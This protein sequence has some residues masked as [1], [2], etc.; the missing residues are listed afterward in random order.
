MMQITESLAPAS[1]RRL[2]GRRKPFPPVTMLALTVILSILCDLSPAVHPAPSSSAWSLPT[3]NYLFKDTKTKSQSTQYQRDNS[4]NSNINGGSG[5]HVRHLQKS[6]AGGDDSSPSNI[7]SSSGSSAG[8]D[9]KVSSTGRLISSHDIRLTD[10]WGWVRRG[11]SDPTQTTEQRRKQNKNNIR[12]SKGKHKQRH[13]SSSSSSHPSPSF[14][15]SP[16]GSRSRKKEKMENL[17][18]PF[19]EIRGPDG[20]C[21]KAPRFSLY[22]V[23]RK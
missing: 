13:Y 2:A 3:L 5:S 22:R 18:C 16:S 14:S 1:S 6:A 7:Q 17:L 9:G 8:D 10:N 4:Q 19:D 12:H 15:S 20:K 21:R 11:A 23:G